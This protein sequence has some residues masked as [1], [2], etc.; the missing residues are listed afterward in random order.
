[1][2]AAKKV[3][4]TYQKKSSIYSI[5]LGNLVG[6]IVRFTKMHSLGNDFVMLD[7][8]TQRV[9]L[10]AAHIK[11]I[12]DRNLGIGC[13]QIITIEPP[14][15]SNSDFYYRNYNSNGHEAEQ[16][17]NGAR[18]AARFVLD[19]GLASKNKLYADCLAG[20]MSLLVK[21]KNYISVNMGAPR[22]VNLYKNIEVDGKNIEVHAISVGN[23]H[24]ITFVKDIRPVHV[25]KVGRIISESNLFSS[26][27]NVSFVQVVDNDSI[28]LRVFERGVGETL[29]CGSAASASS[30]IANKL[31]L[32]AAK[33]Q[34][35][36]RHGKLDLTI[37]ED[38]KEIFLAGPTNSVY[39]GYFRL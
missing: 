17:G 22:L 19:S 18:C 31:K 26:G 20:K 24:I 36:F 25:N 33:V 2:L 27:A 35:N 32:V 38:N 29:S 5:P 10:H 11:R 14:I 23:P 7:L 34:V 9:R 3:R 21:N 4:C 16:C 13:D 1:M 39:S 28:K 12:A 37:R 30:F 8:I 6:M 15:N